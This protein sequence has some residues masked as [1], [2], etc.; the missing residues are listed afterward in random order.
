MCNSFPFKG[1]IFEGVKTFVT[2]KVNCRGIRK[3]NKQMDK[4]KSISILNDLIE[5]NNDRISG[6]ETA[7]EETEETELKSLFPQF[8]QTSKKCNEELVTQVQ[9]LGG[10]P[11]LGTN[12]KGKVFRAWMGVKTVLMAHHSRSILNSCE[13][14]E[15]AAVDAYN[16]ALYNHKK[17]LS[18]EQHTMI[19]AQS[20]R[21]NAEYDQIKSRRD[22]LTEQK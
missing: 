17:D 22:S 1:L 14:G 9:K 4:E 19:S 12:T 6:Y 7:L 3:S 16:N 18:V 10:T 20:A 15:N 5:I 8:A 11:T 13:I 2:L 21:I